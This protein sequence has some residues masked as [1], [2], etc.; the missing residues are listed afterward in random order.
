MSYI[1][2]PPVSGDFIVLDNITASATA[3]YTLQRNSG[4]FVPESA[5]HMLV[6]LNGSIQKP[7][8]SFT[9][10]GSTITFSQ[11][12]TSSDSID[13]IL[14]LGNVNAVGVA[15]T[16]SDSA[17]TDAKTNFVSTSSGAGLQIKGDGTTD[18]TL[19]LNC[20]QNSHGIKL[21]SPAHSAGQSYTLTFPTTAPS[22]N[23]ILQTDGSGNLSFATLSSDYVLI[24][25]A[26]TSSAGSM[27]FKSTT[28]GGT[29]DFSTYER[30]DIEILNHT[31]TGSSA[32]YNMYAQFLD[33]SGNAITSSNYNWTSQASSRN[34]SSS[35]GVPANADS[36]RISR[37]HVGNQSGRR[38]NLHITVYDF[39]NTD[40]Y[41]S[42]VFFNNV[43][44]HDATAHIYPTYTVGYF[45]G[46]TNEM[47]GFKIFYSG[48]NVADG[49]I[50]K[51]YGKK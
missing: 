2:V 33:T 51:I 26:T 38:S 46:N 25:T 29:L 1:G 3:S 22:A 37:D 28:R 23:K 11:A 24:S 49:T 19:Q 13:F 17:I 5:N 20:S 6:S 31:H 30:F 40:R 27:E 21:K 10:S 41:K 9:V 12:L 4:N 43:M 50:V 18:G 42:L 36:I 7:N 35:D 14:V 44:N 47:G 48:T 16:V 34:G 39:T 32:T 8:S 15:T 45:V